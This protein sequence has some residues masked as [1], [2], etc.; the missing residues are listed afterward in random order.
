MQI[1]EDEKVSLSQTVEIQDRPEIFGWFQM[2]RHFLAMYH[3]RPQWNNRQFDHSS[4]SHRD[5]QNFDP[6]KF[7]R[8]PS[9]MLPY[10][11]TSL[12]H[13]ILHQHSASK[14]ACKI[15]KS[16]FQELI[17]RTTLPFNNEEPLLLHGFHGVS[18]L[19]PRKCER[20]SHCMRHSRRQSSCMRWVRHGQGSNADF[21]MLQRAATACSEC[22]NSW[23][24]EGYLPMLEGGSQVIGGSGQVFEQNS[25][26][27]RHQSWL[28]CLHRHQLWNVSR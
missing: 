21:R 22:E 16:T 11:N 12:S 7:P 13:F 8:V 20:G 27:L 26:R 19:L 2:Y 3:H 17:T 18:H 23:W 4:N 10:I 15:P 24:Q 6:H 1:Q 5:T 9:I 28:P 14:S 25:K